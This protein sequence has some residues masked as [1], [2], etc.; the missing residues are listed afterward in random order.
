MRYTLQW[1]ATGDS[2][3]SMVPNNS[4]AA[5]KKDTSLQK[6]SDL[7]LHY[8]YGAAAVKRWGQ[9]KDAFQRKAKPPRPPLPETVEMRPSKS[10]HGRTPAIQKHEAAGNAEAEPPRITC[11]W[12]A[13]D[14]VGDGNAM[15]GPGVEGIVHSEG[16]EQWD[17]DDVMLFFWGNSKASKDRHCE[18][19]EESTRHM[20][21]WREGVAQDSV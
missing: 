11:H 6:P 20:E 7:L 1:L 3:R 13:Q 17:E 12:Q 2:A 5:F 18:K 4:D 10:T 9:G 8:N 14:G 21:Q 15:A 19:L 16:Q